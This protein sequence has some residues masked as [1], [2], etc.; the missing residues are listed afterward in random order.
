MLDKEFAYCRES[1][2]GR[3]MRGKLQTGR[4]E[5]AADRGARSVQGRARLQ[6]G[7]RARGG[8]HP[9]HAAHVCDAGRVEAERLVE[10]LVALPSRK[11]G[12]TMR[13]EVWTGRRESVGRR[14][15]TSG[16]HGE[17]ARL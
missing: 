15:R 4:P 5:V 16:L 7:S 11:K 8:A 14:Q 10:L 9:E 2:Q 6:I 12:R 3:A 1:K 13:S 17:R